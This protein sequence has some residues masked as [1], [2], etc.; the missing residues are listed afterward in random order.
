[1]ALLNILRSSSLD[2]LNIVRFIVIYMVLL[3]L[4]LGLMKTSLGLKLFSSFCKF[5][6]LL[7]LTGTMLEPSGYRDTSRLGSLLSE[8]KNALDLSTSIFTFDSKI[9]RPSNANVADIEA[10]LLYTSPSPRD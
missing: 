7:N 9:F 3:V 4:V 2:F 8:S 6:L 1:M 5:T 10:C